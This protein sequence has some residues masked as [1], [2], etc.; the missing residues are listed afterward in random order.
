MLRDYIELS[1]PKDWIKNVFVFM[2]VPFALASGAAL[3]PAVFGL[4]L[5]AFCLGSSAVYAFNDALDAERDRAHEKKRKR[6][7]ASGRVSLLQAKLWSLA[8]V[9]ASIGL[10][11]ASASMPAL[12]IL[13]VYLTINTAYC[14]G[15]KNIALLDVFLLASGFVLRVLLGCALLDVPPSHPMLLCSYALALFLAL[16]KRRADVTK[17]LDSSHRP[18]LLGYNQSFLD[19]AMTITAAMAVVGYAL[20]SLESNVLIQT[21]KFASLPFVLFGVLDYMRLVHVRKTGGSPVDLLLA[22]PALLVTGVG[23][24]IAV[25]WSVKLP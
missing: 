24:L 2:P 10:A 22:S 13:L 21:R 17:G 25:W 12:A 6:P 1:R 23:W 4:G 11:F 5:T 19:H 20:Y 7:V 16:A 9:V 18:S 14:L 15:A 8:L 3:K